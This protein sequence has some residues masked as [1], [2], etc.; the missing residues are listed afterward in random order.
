[1]AL[2]DNVKLSLRIKNSAYDSEIT[3]LIDSCKADMKISGIA[4]IE[5]TD[6]LTAQAIKLY[7]KGSFG[8]DENSEKFIAAYAN[9]KIAMALSGDYEVVTVSV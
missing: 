7:C 3:D 9:L 6:P 2:I 4:K 1:M 8:Y 5:E